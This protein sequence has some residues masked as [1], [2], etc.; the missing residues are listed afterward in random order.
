MADLNARTRL[1]VGTTA[2]WSS[3][4]LVLGDG[5]VVLERAGSLVK[6]KAGNGTARY[7]ALPFL[8]MQPIVPAEYVTQDEGDARY[9]QL[10]GISTTGGAPAGNKVPRMLGT[11]LLDPSTIPLPPAIATGGTPADAGKLVKTASTGKID[12]TFI[13]SITGKYRGTTNATTTAPAGP[14]VAG[15]YYVN[16]ATGLAHASWGLPAGTNVAPGQQLVYNGAAWDVIGTG[17]VT[18]VQ[19][20]NGAASAPSL[21]FVNDLGLGLYRP[22]SNILGFSSGGVEK[23]RL[24]ASGDAQLLLGTAA[25]GLGAAG[26][27]LVEVSGSAGAALALD[28]AG[29]PA[30]YLNATASVFNVGAVGRPLVL[31]VDGVEKARVP[32]GN[33]AQWLVGTSVLNLAGTGRGSFA[34]NGSAGALVELQAGAATTGY[35][36]STP[37]QLEIGA[38]GTAYIDF[39]TGNV[40]RARIAASGTFTY[41]AYEVGWRDAPMLLR[42]TAG[43]YVLA[44]GDRGCTLMVMSPASSVVLNQN[45][46][47]GGA[48][49]RIFNNTGAAL[50]LTQGAGAT[51]RWNVGGSYTTGSRT[52]AINALVEIW[53]ADAVNGVLTGAGVT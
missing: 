1:L 27:G 33:D 8:A 22:G 37:T 3:S 47:T 25:A 51:L 12:P 2:D 40:E 38:Q 50:P 30:A 29:V 26:R 7:S 42:N 19:L 4:D 9:L 46:F 49:I 23:M 6:M 45:V 34:L 44:P 5:E 32:V 16:T 43:A 39:V 20:P 48:V 28:V 13:T 36:A 18:L 41:G 53:M 35:V 52:L 21:A 14:F 31:Y 15:D 11:G 17:A 24:T 10:T